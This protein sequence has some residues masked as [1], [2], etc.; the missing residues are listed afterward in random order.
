MWITEPREHG[1][2][3]VFGNVRYS[4]VK[5]HKYTGIGDSAVVVK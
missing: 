2:G 1:I 5:S 3:S 4:A